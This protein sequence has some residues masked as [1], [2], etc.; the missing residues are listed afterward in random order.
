MQILG[1]LGERLVQGV[2]DCVE[3]TAYWDIWTYT[4]IYIVYL[5]QH[6]VVLLGPALLRKRWMHLRQ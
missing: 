3:W 5:F 1:G 4:I 2:H 6:R